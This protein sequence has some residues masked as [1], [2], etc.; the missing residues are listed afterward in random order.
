[1]TGSIASGPKVFEIA[2]SETE[3]G[4]QKGDL[5]RKDEIAIEILMQTIVIAES[6][7]QEK[8]RR[9]HLSCCV[10][11]LEIARMIRGI[12]YGV[13]HDLVPPIRDCG[14]S[15]VKRFA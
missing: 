7:L 9:P 8:R 3:A 10:A 1:M 2:T 5:Q 14:E 6:V 11:P 15:G 13:A 4:E 12:A